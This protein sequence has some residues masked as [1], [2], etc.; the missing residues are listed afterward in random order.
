MTNGS[1]V[2]ILP[3]IPPEVEQFAAVKGLNGYLNAVIDLAGRAFPSCGLSLTLGQD[4]EDETH[5]YIA[6]DVDAGA[7]RS[8]SCWP[9][10]ESGPR[11][12]GAF[13]PHAKPFILC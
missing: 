3:V 5:R 1:M 9:G 2:A 4:A 6:I 10:S 7:K 13:A 11:N 8:K 12:S